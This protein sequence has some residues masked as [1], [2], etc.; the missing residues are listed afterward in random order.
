MLSK[1]YSQLALIYDRL[2]IHV[3]YKIWSDYIKNLYQ[4]GDNKISKVVDLSCGTGKHIKYLINKKTK[5]Y[6][7]D[8]SLPMIIQAKKNLK[9]AGKPKVFVNDATT[10]AIKP[11]NF[12]CALMLYDSINYLIDEENIMRIFDEVFRILCAGSIFIFDVVTKKGLKESFD[13]YFESDTFDKLAFERHGWFEQKKNL[14]HNEFKLIYDGNFYQEHHIQKI[15]SI[16]NWQK[17]L[18]HSKMTLIH[19]FSN[20]TLLP[21]DEK[22]ER[23]HFICKKLK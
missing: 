6:G 4:F 15:R 3:N 13:G 18:K 7:A 5:Y 11:N 12:D 21:A 17:L 2:M 8:Y 22:S 20:F 19:S 16:N 1:E 9:N 10:M 14:Q 23:V